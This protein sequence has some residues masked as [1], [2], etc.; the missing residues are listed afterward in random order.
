MCRDHALVLT[1]LLMH[2]GVNAV[3][4]TGRLTMFSGPQEGKQP[5]GLSFVPHA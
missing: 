1:G 5:R 2:I 4:A 3:M